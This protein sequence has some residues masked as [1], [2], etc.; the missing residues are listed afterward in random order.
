MVDWRPAPYAVESTAPGTLAAALRPRRMEER[1]P[2]MAPE[3]SVTHRWTS[4]P[5][6][7]ASA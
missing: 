6:V 4:E 1:T 2:L 5:L 3:F 7:S